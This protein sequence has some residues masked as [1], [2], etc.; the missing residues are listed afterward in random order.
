[1]EDMTVNLPIRCSVAD[2][3]II[4]VL[5]ANRSRAAFLQTLLREAGEEAA[6][7]A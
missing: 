2:T 3:E 5:R 6:P 1:M 7:C 4:D